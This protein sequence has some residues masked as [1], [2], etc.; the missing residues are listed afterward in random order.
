VRPLPQLHAE[1]LL[2]RESVEQETAIEA[3]SRAA[4]MDALRK[5]VHEELKGLERGVEASLSAEHDLWREYEALLPRLERQVILKT[6][7][8]TEKGKEIDKEIGEI[9][10][11]N[12]EIQPKNG[13]IRKMEKLINEWRGKMEK[14]WRKKSQPIDTHQHT[15]DVFDV[16][17]GAAEAGHAACRS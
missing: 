2:V 1:L 15:I 6:N 17:D 8:K 13:G 7:R 11:K 9:N 10:T 3:R 14:Q 12:G 5:A 16:A 4:A